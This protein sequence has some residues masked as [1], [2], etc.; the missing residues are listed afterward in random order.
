MPATVGKMKDIFRMHRISVAASLVALAIIASPAAC[1]AQ[2]G[3][4]AAVGSHGAGSGGVGDSSKLGSEPTRGTNAAGTAQ[5]TGVGPH[6]RPGVT[7]GA[8][9]RRGDAVISR[10]DKEV[11]KKVDKKIKSICRG[12]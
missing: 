2:S 1:F 9:N 7:T 10:E 4:G 8:A 3:G 11:D 6:V 12:C 5:S